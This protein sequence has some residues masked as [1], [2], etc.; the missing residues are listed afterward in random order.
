MK[1]SARAIAT[2]VGLLLV[3]PGSGVAQANHSWNDFHW[4][5]RDG[6]VRLYANV[7]Q[8]HDGFVQDTASVLAR[9][10]ASEHVVMET[11][12]YGKQGAFVVRSGDFGR[13]G[14]LG[15]TKIQLDD[16][17]HIVG[18][19]VQLNE[20]YWQQGVAGYDDAAR[21]HVYCQEVGHILGLA[22]Q[23][24]PGDSCMNDESSELGRY[25]QPNSH[26]YV[27]L[28][29]IYR[30][31]EGWESGTYAS[32]RSHQC[33][34]DGCRDE[35]RA[36]QDGDSPDVDHLLDLDHLLD[37]GIHPSSRQRWVIAGIFRAPTL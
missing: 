31:G 20:W 37:G 22:H 11:N 18:G 12:P 32:S 30:N 16:S 25:E 4:A 2:I 5:T 13:T 7:S 14:W 3:L 35:Y 27:Q 34:R 36:G 8:V 15:V 28:S 24:D 26:D 17:D 19:E 23:Y 29:Q 33:A 6:V 21:I 9:W 1:R 10:D